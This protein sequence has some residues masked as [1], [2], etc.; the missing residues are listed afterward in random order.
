M[1]KF[2]LILFSCL[3]TL[4]IQ[5]QSTSLSCPTD[6]TIYT[7]SDGVSNYNCST[8]VTAAMNVA[9]SFY[10]PWDLQ[11]LQHKVKGSSIASGSGSV[12]GISMN[13]GLN[14]IT[15]TLFPSNLS[16][17]FNI[18]VLDNEAPKSINIP[19]TVYD[20]CSFPI[21]LSNI[22]VPYDNCNSDATLTILSEVETDLGVSCATKTDLQKYTKKLVRTFEITD[23]EGNKSNFTQTHYTRDKNPPILVLDSTK[24]VNIGNINMVYPTANFN[25]GSFDGCGG[26]VI[27]KG[28]LGGGCSN[29]SSNLTL[30]KSLIPTGKNEIVLIVRVRGEDK[31]SNFSTIKEI[32][33]LLK[34]IQ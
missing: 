14:T 28:C 26:A 33:L 20:T 12:A 30:K 4:N 10:D 8:L 22:P 24:V 17:D 29:F 9:P 6:K 2:I 27:L 13:K 7:N 5:A 16:C 23:I 15:Y 34:K 1:L 32:P 31:C 21:V 11:S 18:T 25:N 19:T 3:F